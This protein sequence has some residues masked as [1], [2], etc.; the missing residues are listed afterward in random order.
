MWE[1]LQRGPTR[2]GKSDCDRSVDGS[3]LTCQTWS[4]VILR[5]GWKP[6]ADGSRADAQDPVI[7]LDQVKGLRA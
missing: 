3:T 7:A 4:A 5:C 2:V 1:P 6:I